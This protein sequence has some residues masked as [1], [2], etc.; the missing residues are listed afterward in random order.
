MLTQAQL[1]TKDSRGTSFAGGN[2]IIGYPRPADY[3]DGNSQPGGKI[4]QGENLN[5]KFN[6]AEIYALHRKKTEKVMRVVVALV[7]AV[8][9]VTLYFLL[10]ND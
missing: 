6:E 10:T 1:V 9:A 7:V 5:D 2:V 3:P 4:R 8:F